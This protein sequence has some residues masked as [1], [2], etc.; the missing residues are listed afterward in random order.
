MPPKRCPECGRFLSNELVA[1]LADTS[2]PCPRCETPLEA[3]KLVGGSGAARRP[4]RRQAAPAQPEAAEPA[5]VE[6]VTQPPVG[7]SAVDAV[8]PV[9]AA[10]PVAPAV[11]SEVGQAPDDAA[12]VAEPPAAVASADAAA[13]IRPPDLDPRQVQD[14][15]ED[16]LAGWDVG[17][18]PE[19]IAAWRADR[20]PFP[21][22]T[23]SIAVG[24]VLGAV[25]GV[26]VTERRRALGAALGGVGG[27]A[28]VAAVRRLW[29]LP[30]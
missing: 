13:S 5:P 12:S 25:I 26:V 21:A 17:A 24:A 6:A 14:P 4:S 30:G 8:D 20:R 23:V 15:G 10:A 28:V 16:V 19:E 7:G 2:Q 9:D 27:I 11:T 3:D 1:S 22:D 29:E 18:T